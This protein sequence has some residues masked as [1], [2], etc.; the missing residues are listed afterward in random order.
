MDCLFCKIVNKEI[1]ASI[2]YEDNRV[3]AFNDINPQA[4]THILV[5]PKKHVAGV[6]QLAA[7]DESLVGYLFT[8]LQKLARDMGIEQS[9]YRIVANNGR[10]AGQAVGH[11]HFHLLGGRALAWPPG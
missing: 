7:A 10:D 6:A 4:P 1:P 3:L 2:V 11:L 5:I 9:G 8:V